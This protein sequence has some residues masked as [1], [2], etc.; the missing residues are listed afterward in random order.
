MDSKKVNT[1]KVHKIENLKLE[2]GGMRPDLPTFRADEVSKHDTNGSFWVTYKHGVYDITKFLPSHPG[3]EQI[4]NAGGLSVEPFWNVY[5]NHKTEEVFELLETFR[6]GNLHDDDVVDHSDEELWAKEPARDARLL[7]RTRRPFN[8]ETPPQHQIAHFDT[9]NEL[10]FVRQHMPVPELEASSHKLRISI[11]QGGR[12]TSRDF[13]LEDLDKFPQSQLSAALM[14][15]GNRRSEMNKEVKPAKGVGWSGGAVSNALWSGV[16]L[17]DVLLHCGVDVDDVEGKHVIF[18]GSDVDATGANFSTSIPLAQ[19]LAAD[20]RVLL[21]TRM[22]GRALPPDH[23]RP[24]RAVVPG[25]PAVRSVKWLE[26]V[27]VSE[28]ESPSHWHQKDYRSFNASVDWAS[29]DFAGAPPV[30]GMPVTS[31]VCEPQNGAR[32]PVRGGRVLVRGYAYSGGGAK[33]VRVDV[34]PDGGRTWLAAR[35]T[36]AAGDSPGRHYAWTLWACE[37]PVQPGQDEMEVWVKATDSNM[38]TQPERFAHIWNI[39]G[40]L[41][42]AYHKVTFKLQH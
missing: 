42:N 4:L 11:E 19:A 27:T 32:A 12:S 8:A 3:G 34:S 16:Y 26:A 22:N 38:N 15:A 23:G 1:V 14:C 17:R 33:V 6:I 7:V 35:P 20:A 37:V 28:R 30:Y 29:A 21:A 31:A 25:A 13:S 10:F 18:Q 40:I 36:H 5:G 24:L 2:A 41:G 39:R 9:P